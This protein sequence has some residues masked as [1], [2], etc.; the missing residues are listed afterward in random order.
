MI[1]LFDRTQKINIFFLHFYALILAIR[2]TA[3]FLPK[4]VRS[5]ID[6]IL[7]LYARGSTQKVVVAPTVFL[8]EI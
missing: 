3:T 5:K 7:M 1:Y 2:T 8:K 4:N 6:N